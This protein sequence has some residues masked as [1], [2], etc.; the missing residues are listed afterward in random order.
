MLY[1][2]LDA[3]RRLDQP[4]ITQ[5]HFAFHNIQSIYFVFDLKTGADL[6]HYLRK[7][8]LFEE[9]NVAFYVACISSALHYCHSKHVIHRD[10]KPENIILDEHGF[11]CLI[12]FGVAHVQKPVSSATGSSTS[13]LSAGTLV[14]TSTTSPF[15]A[16]FKTGTGTAGAATQSASGSA[17]NSTTTSSTGS[18]RTSG[19]STDTASS[20][21]GG[22]SGY[23]YMRAKPTPIDMERTLTSR[24]ASGTKQYLA[25]EVFTSKHVHG[26]EV[27]FWA[28]GVVAYELLHGRRPFDKH[29]PKEMIN[30]LDKAYDTQS[31]RNANTKQMRDRS[32]AAYNYRIAGSGSGFLSSI[33]PSRITGGNASPTHGSSS[34]SSYASPTKL[35]LQELDCNVGGGSYSGSANVNAS[36]SANSTGSCGTSVIASAAASA[37]CTECGH[38]G[39]HSMN[40]SGAN[41]KYIQS[42]YGGLPSAVLLPESAVKHVTVGCGT[43]L[44]G[45]TAA[46]SAGAIVT[47]KGAVSA[48]NVDQLSSEI[49]SGDQRPPLSS[50]SN[51]G[52]GNGGVLLDELCSLSIA[53]P[54]GANSRQIPS[55]VYSAPTTPQRGMHAETSAM[56]SNTSQVQSPM[57]SRGGSLAGSVASTPFGSP[58][59]SVSNTPRGS[60][61]SSR[62]GSSEK[63]GMG[64]P[65]L[66]KPNLASGSASGSASPSAVSTHLFGSGRDDKSDGGGTDR[67][68]DSPAPMLQN[69]SHGS[70]SGS[71][72]GSGSANASASASATGRESSVPVFPPLCAT[73]NTSVGNI[74]NGSAGGSWIMDSNGNDA[75]GESEIGARET[76]HEDREWRNG[77]TNTKTNTT[78]TR[79][80]ASTSANGL[81]STNTAECANG[82]CGCT[83][84]CCANWHGVEDGMGAIYGNHW[85]TEEHPNPKKSKKNLLKVEV[86]DYNVWLGNLSKSCVDCIGGLFEIRPAHRLGGRNIHALRTHNWMKDHGLSDWNLLKTKVP[87]CAPHFMPGKSYIQKKYGTSHPMSTEPISYQKQQKHLQNSNDR[88]RNGQLVASKISREQE[89]E[90]HKFSYGAPAFN[91][92]LPKKASKSNSNKGSNGSYTGAGSGNIASTAGTSNHVCLPTAIQKAQQQQ[93]PIVVVASPSHSGGSGN[94][95]D[96]DNNINNSFYK[97]KQ[98]IAAQMRDITCNAHAAPVGYPARSASASGSCSGGDLSALNISSAA[99]NTFNGGHSGATPYAAPSNSPS[100]QMKLAATMHQRM[101]AGGGGAVNIK[102][103]NNS[104][105]PPLAN[106]VV[107][108]AAAAAAAAAASSIDPEKKKSVQVTPQYGAS[109]S[110]ASGKGRPSTTNVSSPNHD[111]TTYQ[112]NNGTSFGSNAKTAKAIAYYHGGNTGHAGF[113]GL[114][115]AGSGLFRSAD[116]LGKSEHSKANA[117]GVQL[118]LGNSNTNMYFNANANSRQTPSGGGQ[119]GMQGSNGPARKK[120]GLSSNALQK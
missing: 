68:E 25:P 13:G 91:Y 16:A 109:A 29:C 55:G 5:L 21:I 76:I 61:P 22:A 38:S 104:N 12:D 63:D 94:D 87:N 100:D 69:G 3:L 50:D 59:A 14:S 86:P 66:A 103:N 54:S 74:A 6:R 34:N 78:S 113:G 58:C 24:L 77:S 53:S 42:F 41:S 26:P 39:S 35:Q 80:G 57:T 88:D 33:M 95:S 106:P 118:P 119:Q 19:A 2:E 105:A 93:S 90:F 82:N 7:K 114:N 67:G 70:L 111:D 30:Y 64:C 83:V 48:T 10:V 31:E 43:T 47:V 49:D 108:A 79:D 9:V 85:A 27:D 99:G 45:G 107:V 96:G 62:I 89:S 28:L 102:G 101:P 84:M 98:N 44:T 65:G 36:A 51:I 23:T 4:F 117:K 8:L 110:A 32:A 112:G 1:S 116:L 56:L 37:V 20:S 72:S 120:F 92:L 115:S 71:G 52:N 15:A 40:A 73:Q 17:S 11:P 97:P 18:G 81:N 46:T 75:S 60:A